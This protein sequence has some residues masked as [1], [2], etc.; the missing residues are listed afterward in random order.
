MREQDQSLQNFRLISGPALAA[1]LLTII[2]ANV[3]S[4]SLQA[5]QSQAPAPAPA[6]T[7][8]PAPSTPPAT[9]TPAPPSTPPAAAT[10]KAP[11]APQFSE[12]EMAFAKQ[13]TA[14]RQQDALEAI[15]EADPK[16]ITEGLYR[17]VRQIG[18]KASDNDPHLARSIYMEAE[19]VATR[20]GLSILAADSHVNLARQISLDGDPY[21]AITVYNQA[22]AMYQAANAPPQKRAGTLLNRAMSYLDMGDYQSSIDDGNEAMRISRQNGDE[23]A[24]AR[25]ENGL[26]N[27][28]RDLGRFSE[29]E[30][31]FTDALRIAR[32]NGQKL[33]EA[34]VL[35]NMSMLHETEGDYPTA[36]K[37]CEQSLAIKRELGSKFNIATS[38]IN[39]ANYYDLDKRDKDANRMLTEAAQIG[40]EIKMKEI[41]AKATSEMGVIELEHHHPAAALKLLSEGR[42]IGA[43]VEDKEGLAQ[44][45]R[46]MAEANFDLKN[47][48]ESLRHAK[49][50][51]DFCRRWGMLEQL[52]NADYV[53]ARA[54]VQMKQLKEARAA[55]EE[56]IA[57]IERMRDN[58]SGGAA[59]RQRFMEKRTEPYRLLAL[60]A[61]MQKDWPVALTSSERGK[62]RILLD[63]YTGSGLTSDA[64]LSDAERAEEARLRSSFVSL[65][66]QAD[67]QASMPEVDP[68]QK[69]ALDDSVDK[70]RADLA[71]YREQLYEHHPELRIRRADLSPLTLKDMQ[72]LIPDGTTV[73]LEYELSSSGN[74]LYAV[75]RGEGET[76]TI[77]G[78]KLAVTEGELNRRVRQYHDQL[79]SRDPEFAS[80]A[81]WLYNALIA[82][83]QAQLR[84]AKA[85]VVV[86]D[87]VLWQAPFQ[88][89]QRPDGH[90]LLEQTAVDYVPSI[91]VLQAL[92]A[93][94]PRQHPAFTVLAMGDPGGQ[95][96][97]QAN[98][99]LAVAKLYG[100]KNARTL[101][102]KAATLD[103]FLKISP[104]YDVVH[105]AAHGV[106]DDREPMSSHMLLASSSGTPQAGWLRAREIQ[107]MQLEAELVV[108]S[109]CET[110]K[111]SFEDGEGLVGMSWATLAAG[112]H[113][114]LAS[115][116]RVEASSTTELMI[117]FHRN[118]LH[119]L[120]KAESLRMAELQVMHSDK[121]A[122]PFYWAA[123]VLMG[124]GVA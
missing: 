28:L 96:Q 99:T 8:S 3:P 83:A 48:P 107:A 29:A 7:T 82:P 40:R 105:I 112:A 81:R 118:M 116:W 91:A 58:V 52:Y 13:L 73:L 34:F 54:Y 104:D 42:Y 74:Y 64:A 110:G 55:L 45:V 102:G 46:I 22:L 71:A 85:L 77:H 27:A 106:F 114:S 123:F 11:P 93:S 23:V 119:G 87:G 120:S 60:V 76:A 35:N 41:T 38:L 75:T 10:P 26:G 31:A 79:A 21:E 80:N 103:E 50:A 4:A 1:I 14:M 25:A 24:V 94:A 122:H 36:I 90:Y 12:A 101:I 124:D 56:S 108:L 115:A 15:Q 17:A 117:A 33:G 86:P 43:D 63:L 66:M 53:E 20:A 49:Y 111:G 59:A 2:A 51:A 44:T 72:V 88:T 37:F 78:Y 68:S 47:Y 39:L 97:E 98:E 16:R 65:D 30:A 9:N 121:Y 32:E 5:Q 62:G 19:A 100:P 109:G 70:A 92:K 57:T 18:I 69:M 84:A 89:L 6:S 67:R 113:G 95:T 61:S